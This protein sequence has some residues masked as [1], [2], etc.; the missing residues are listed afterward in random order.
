MKI[1]RAEFTNFRLLRNLILEFSTDPI[2]KLTVIRAENESG[3]TTILNGLQWALYGDDALPG[4]RKNYRLHP[5][6]WIGSDNERVP[7]AVEVD[8]ETSS[9]RRTRSGEQIA[10][11]KEYRLLRTT[12]DVLQGDGWDPGPGSV[13]L[14]EVTPSGHRPID[15]PE[16]RIQD[17]LPR[18]L[19]E[20]F[21]TDGDRALS[22]IEADV[23]VS[24][25]QARVRGAIQSLLGLDVI[26]DTQKRVKRVASDVNKQARKIS[27]NVEL[28]ET[29]DRLAKFQNEAADLEE[30]IMDAEEQFANF[31][32]RF[33]EIDK[34]IQEALLKG[35]REELQRDISQTQSQV[36]SLNSQ[37]EQ[38]QKAHSNLFKSLSLSRD[39]ANP[40]MARSLGQLDTLRDQGKIPNTS[41][42]I[43]EE[44]LASTTCICGEPLQGENE[45]AVR[46]KA[47]IQHLIEESRRTDALQESITQL[48]FGS[49][50]LQIG[51]AAPESNWQTHLE[52]VWARRDE[53]DRLRDESGK[54]LK[55]LET[56]IAQIPDS[57]LQG[58]RAS[59]RQFGTQRDRYN[60]DIARYQADFNNIKREQL[61]LSKKR[62]LLLRQQ[63]KGVRIMADL[64]VAQD[65]DTVLTNAY[66]RLTTEE[67][68]KVSSRMNDVFLEMIGA[69][70]QQGAI[71]RRA[72]ITPQFEILVHGP[73]DRPLNPDRDLNGASRRALTL[74]FILALTQVSEVE[75]PNVIDTPLG[76]MSGF[77]KRSVLTTV[78]RE[79]SQLILFL[80]RSEIADCED[81]LD[82]EGGQVITLT[83]PS[84]YPVML[85]HEPSVKERSIVKCECNHWQACKLCQ[86]KET[87]SIEMA[88]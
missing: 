19:R 8:F 64:E 31:D 10:T 68:E 48:Y 76:M 38:A 22:F 88:M 39:L 27:S 49:L 50:S 29:V 45:D 83:N 74:A 71:I 51:R 15:P 85:I 47:H 43:L 62:D 60:A 53:I 35:N 23:S 25:K 11:K 41:I 6:D 46:R 21:F 9:L 12:Y 55:A 24:T 44:R 67:L 75:A 7:I 1:I 30:K 4:G 17:E 37:Q 18:E 57:D 36:K 81:I 5:I 69:D 63:D 20:I 32:E 78:I 28:T 77:V 72:M 84:H 2:K 66:R 52:N 82:A 58:L 54:R 3:K 33:A 34:K 16:A 40:L 87:A 14:F 73:N 70:P 79:S 61:E 86:R 42:P 56:K 26:E 65:I 80:T 13:Q 59:K